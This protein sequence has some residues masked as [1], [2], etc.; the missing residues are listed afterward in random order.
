MTKNSASLNRTL[1][2]ADNLSLLE[3]LDNES[4]DLICIDPPFAKNQTFVGALRPPLSKEEREQELATL[5]DWG[6]RNRADAAAA[7]IEA[8]APRKGKRNPFREILYG[9]VSSVLYSIQAYREEI[10]RI[11]NQDMGLDTSVKEAVVREYR[12]K[13]GDTGSTEVQ[14]ALLTTRIVNLTNHLRRHIHDES[15]RRGLM[16]LVGRRRRLLKYLN[17]EDEGRY[18]S[19]VA[20]LGLRG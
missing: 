8:P 9:A 20:R 2:I 18:R 6:I 13:D 5:A 12:T 17:R 7:G 14:I 15:T 4:I 3:S 11:A 10:H 1:F 16:K 19:I